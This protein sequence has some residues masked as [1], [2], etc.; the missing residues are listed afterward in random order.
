[1][2]EIMKN[3]K[4][5]LTF[6]LLIGSM[7]QTKA[8][9]RAFQSGSSSSAAKTALLNIR[10]S[11][12]KFSY[13]PSDIW[14]TGVHDDFFEDNLNRYFSEKLPHF[15]I[16]TFL[17]H[18]GTNLLLTDIERNF[19]SRLKAGLEKVKS[20]VMSS[21]TLEVSRD[22]ISHSSFIRA[23]LRS[24]L[25][26]NLG[27]KFLINKPLVEVKTLQGLDNLMPEAPLK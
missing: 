26:L 24:T 23:V 6:V 22:E 15:I 13:E 19:V 14:Y 11:M 17:T 7:V 27:C 5:F 4:A 12:A 10:R 1:M 21:F 9:M 25:E 16:D 20:G 3:A 8:M 18:L 2:E